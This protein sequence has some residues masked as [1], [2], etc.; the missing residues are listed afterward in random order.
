MVVHL[1][2]SVYW[3][4]F[5]WN[6]GGFPRQTAIWIYCGSL[7]WL[8]IRTFSSCLV[9]SYRCRV[10]VSGAGVHH[11]ILSGRGRKKP[12]GIHIFPCIRN[13]KPGFSQ[14]LGCQ[15]PAERN[16]PVQQQESSSFP[17]G[18]R[19]RRAPQRQGERRRE[20]WI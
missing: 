16:P 8:R 5:F 20:L 1:T 15:S 9:F 19:P 2:F 12:D 4:A 11:P 18:G 6:E 14:R 7:L 10:S 13:R 17:E 3:S